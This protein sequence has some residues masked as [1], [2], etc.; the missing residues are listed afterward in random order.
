MK[1][2]ITKFLNKINCIING[3]RYE[4][5]FFKPKYK[6][7]YNNLSCSLGYYCVVCGRKK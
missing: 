6:S 2:Y 3:H 5:Q 7:R 1:K 4:E